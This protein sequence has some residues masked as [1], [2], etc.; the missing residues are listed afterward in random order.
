MILGRQC[1]L[2]AAAVF[3]M[4]WLDGAPRWWVA[5]VIALSA[6]LQPLWPRAAGRYISEAQ[7][8]HDLVGL[9][10]V[11]WF[12][13]ELWPLTMLWVGMITAW[14]ALIGPRRVSL[15]MTLVMV[16]GGAV[17]GV[18]RSIDHFAVAVFGIALLGI[19]M[20][21][22]GFELRRE[23][24]QNES[25]LMDAL[26]AAG[27]T[28]HHSDLDRGSVASIEGDI[29]RLT[30]WNAQEWCASDHRRMIHPD[31][32]ATYWVDVDAVDPDTVID[33]VARMRRKDGSWIWVR[34]VA[35]V[36]IGTDGHRTMRGFS[37]DVTEVEEAADTIAR[38]VREDPLTG[39]PNRLA[40]TEHLSHL[41]EGGTEFALLLTDLDRFKEINDTLGHEAGDQLL[42]AIARRLAA[43]AGPDRLVARLGGDE[44]AVVAVAA[45][46]EDAALLA[47]QIAA[48]CSR[49]TTVQGVDVAVASSTGIA[50]SASSGASRATA[51]RH[52]DIAM[53][54]AKRSG[55]GFRVF[56]GS[57]EQ[58]STQRL[59]LSASLADAID[60][61]ELVLH[62]QPKYHL[63]TRALV[64]AEGLARWEHPE[65]GTL[66]PSHFL[67]LALV[68]ENAGRFA[69][70][71]IDDA[72]RMIRRLA[73]AGGAMPIAVNVAMGA[74]R[75]G[76]FAS[77]LLDTL[78]RHDVAPELLVLEFTESDPLWPSPSVL[79]GLQTIV[80]AGVRLSI[81][82][83]GTGHSSLERLC[84]LSI[85]EIKIDRSFVDAM[86]TEPLQHQ[87]VRTI[88]DLAA[89]LDHELVAEGVETEAQAA[90]LLELGCTV[91][92]GYL[93]AKP[94]SADDFEH[95]VRTETCTER[96]PGIVSAC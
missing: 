55:L 77:D 91:G 67:D 16:A 8:V 36:S 93:F 47:K 88:I 87:I 39:L 11:T 22:Y 29:E 3:T 13:P 66:P 53:Y 10:V 45:S 52:A 78:A 89:G 43:V 17:V 63:G 92:Q 12:A 84:A 27:A 79:A 20:S 38:Q 75:H 7:S 56:D 37:L 80:D 61:G 83:F 76:T 6:T 28:V 49:P 41:I 70:A 59:S 42:Q 26:S 48:E 62:F 82:D 2:L 86:M 15:A 34:D 71:M 51:M 5:V 46:L 90:R 72:A 19:A 33:R 58:T 68:S 25:T 95:L 64:G 69:L 18:G 94:M 30:G 44:Y 9:G 57:L 31:D 21:M 85:D 24:W 81:D 4:L 32:V 65:F 54:D 35:R 14:H 96:R 60:N 74:L 23:V 50:F 40:L 1:A 73:D